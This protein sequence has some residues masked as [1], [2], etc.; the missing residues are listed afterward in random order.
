MLNDKNIPLAAAVSSVWGGAG[1]A[2]AAPDDDPLE[3]R[4]K[5]MAA[6]GG[7]PD[8]YGDRVISDAVLSLFKK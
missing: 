7:A 3:R 4:K 1:I 5:L 2:G 6:V 8:Q